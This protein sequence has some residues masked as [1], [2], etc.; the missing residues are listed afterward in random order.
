MMGSGPGSRRIKCVW[1]WYRCASQGLAQGMNFVSSAANIIPPG[2]EGG[3]PVEGTVSIRPNPVALEVPVNVTG[4]RPSTTVGLRDLFSEETTT[5]LVFKDG[6]VIQLSAAVSVGQ[7]LFLTNKKTSK[8]VVCQILHKRSFKPTICYVDLQFTEEQPD[9]WGV[10]FPE[11]KESLEEIKAGEEVQAEE[12]TADSAETAVSPH[13]PED[14]DE[15]KKEVQALREQ[16]AEMEK[17]NAAQAAA[18]PVPQPAVAASL[19]K[20]ELAS[21]NDQSPEV[22]E[23]QEETKVPG[24]AKAPE[25]P[26]PLLMPEAKETV[27]SARRVIGMALPI[28]KLEREKPTQ[29]TKDP[30]EELLPKPELDFSKMPDH[31]AHLDENDPNSIYKKNNPKTERMRIMGMSAF[32][33][34]LL[35]G[36]AWYGKWWQVL[37][38]KKKAAAA[39]VV[40]KAN[41]PRGAPA[42]SGNGVVATTTPGA[43]PSAPMAGAPAVNA[44]A[45]NATVATGTTAPAT[46]AG[47]NVEKSVGAAPGETRKKDAAVLESKSEETVEAAASAPVAARKKTTVV[48]GSAAAKKNGDD[49]AATDS[50]A[51]EVV[52]SDAPLVPA[53]LVRVAT[54]VYPPDA[55][56]NYITGD[57][58]AEVV[59]DASG[60]VQDVKVLSGPQAL[61]ESAVEAL[62]QYVYEP[63]T[64]GGKTVASKAVAVVKF[65]FNP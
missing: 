24:A 13:K 38:V 20:L 15:L 25:E 34:V 45:T 2:T 51:E 14:V 28:R 41:V 42:P 37:P 57:V 27:A 22:A 12:V 33:L 32:L 48:K 62:K 1:E 54:P 40:P 17:K 23:A 56:R 44:T 19:A 6:A 60:H 55:M 36:G 11:N 9:Y 43:A 21:V 26:Q 3:M 63:A 53:K 8:E 49:N 58:K 59:V 52:A 65:W 10:K 31:P 50:H 16:L 18:V 30:V 46:V 7:L 64:Q 5:V 4:A 47:A 35:I 61:R 29:E 39:P